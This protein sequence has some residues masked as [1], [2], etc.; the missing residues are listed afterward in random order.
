MYQRTILFRADG[1]PT[2]GMGHFTRTLALAEMLKDNFRCVF[3]TQVPTDQQRME[4]ERVC[5]D[6][7]DLPSDNSHFDVFLRILKGDEVVVLD[8]YYFHTDYQ[9]SIKDKGCTLVCIDDMHNQLFMADLIINHAPGIT[10]SDYDAQPYTR[11]ALGLGYALLRPL[12]LEQTQIDRAINKLDTI[13]ICFGGADPTHLTEKALKTI[14]TLKQFSQILVITG[15]AYQPTSEL[16]TLI[17]QDT[18]IDH[19]HSLNEHQMLEAMLEADLAIVPSSSILL[20]LMTV[21]VGILMGYYVENQRDLSNNFGALQI[22]FNLGDLRIDFEEKLL[23]QLN[24]LTLSEVN[25]KVQLQKGFLRNSKN[26]FIQLFK[27]LSL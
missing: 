17:T 13:L 3:A 10:P 22:A 15:A 21:G 2:I 7:V 9:Q 4:M 6:C 19:R 12:F 20:E 27:S 11:F 1:N 24:K 23:E 5:F 14:T 16:S 18:R 8:N 25:E 26:A